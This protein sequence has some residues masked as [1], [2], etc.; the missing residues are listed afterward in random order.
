MIAYDMRYLEKKKMAKKKIFEWSKFLLEVKKPMVVV[1]VAL[2]VN[3][4]LG[5]PSIALG[6]GWAVERAYSHFNWVAK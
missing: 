3:L 2:A 4:G 5:D 6:I 1:L